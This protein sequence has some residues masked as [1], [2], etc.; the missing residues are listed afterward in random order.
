MY[1]ILEI[2]SV[3]SL[4]QSFNTAVASCQSRFRTHTLLFRNFFIVLRTSGLAFFRR[5]CN[6]VKHPHSFFI[7]R[8]QLEK[9]ALQVFKTCGH[10]GSTDKRER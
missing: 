3:R 6:K 4:L 8:Y 1:P 7:F 9:L 2:Y 10:S 5:V